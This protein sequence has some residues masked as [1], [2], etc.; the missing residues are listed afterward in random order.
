[1]CPAAQTITPTRKA[2]LAACALAEQGSYGAVTRLA[3]SHG[4]S[5]QTVYDV[6]EQGEEALLH[7]F[8]GAGQGQGCV[9]V[10]VDAR[11]L[12][13]AVIG[14]R[15]VTPTSI[16]SIEELI[17][18]LYPCVKASYGKVQGLLAEARERAR[19]FNERQELSSI[20]AGTLDEL[21]SQ[22]QPVLAALDLESSYL[23]GLQ[24][25]DARGG[26]QWGGLLRGAQD[27]GA[28]LSVV[29]KDA[30]LGIKA[31]VDR[32][33]PEA[34][35]RDDLFHP[36]RDMGKL[37][38][39]MES[40]AYGQIAREMEAEQALRKTSGARYSP[41]QKLR[42]V[43]ARTNR[44]VEA[45]DAFEEACDRAREALQF[46]DWERG[47][48][49]SAQWMQDELEAAASQM[50]E[51]NDT[52][53]RKLG[54]YLKNRAPGLVLWVNDI[55]DQLE[56]LSQ[57]WGADA[58]RMAVLMWHA[59]R[60]LEATPKSSRSHEQIERMCAAHLGLNHTTTPERAEELFKAVDE[61]LW[62]RHRASSAIEGFNAALRPHLYVHRG[63][64]Q[65]FLEL[66]R[67]AYNLRSRRSGRFKGKSPYERLTGNKVD[68]WLSLIGYPPTSN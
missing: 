39:R 2:H 38:R 30:A 35:Q 55:N 18:I 58:T 32:V 15:T 10:K 9:W 17:P 56:A 5:R 52:K 63:V 29:V 31:G 6:R 3:S 37:L 59:R 42:H 19:A 20:T 21:F 8:H 62:R 48:W 47:R 13:R 64:Q 34:Q 1:M 24:Q 60:D 41:A 53:V 66:F 40:K 51:M 7:G 67:A 16:P 22:G 25:E 68:D 44:V 11:Q 33:F 27:Q 45:F 14:L 57:Q 4:V 26:A 43:R 12:E 49:R 65:G 61:V 54:R 50:L 36:L 28:Q 46:I 23:F